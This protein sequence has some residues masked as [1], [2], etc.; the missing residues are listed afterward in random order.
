MRPRSRRQSREGALGT[1]ERVLAA[2]KFAEPADLATGGAAAGLLWN[3]GGQK[4][5][6][7]LLPKLRAA[8]SSE[9]WLL[10][11]MAV[12]AS[13]LERKSQVEVVR[14]IAELQ[15]WWVLARRLAAAGIRPTRVF[16]DELN[17][18][19][20]LAGTLPLDEKA[21]ARLVEIRESTGFSGVDV[22][23]VFGKPVTPSGLEFL[24]AS[25]P[26]PPAV[27]PLRRTTAPLRLVADTG[28]EGV[29]RKLELW[30][31]RIDDL[32]VSRDL[33]PGKVLRV[34]IKPHRLVA[35]VSFARLPMKVKVP[36]LW[37]LKLDDEL[38]ASVR[39]TRKPVTVALKDGREIRF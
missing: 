16:T 26:A 37:C 3:Q 25:R 19:A 20:A 15:G 28:L 35:S 14:A 18:L 34:E 30:Q 8:A 4:R 39:R 7:S 24:I 6:E 17:G 13:R 23:P 10:A 29:R 9:L 2:K 22:L 11:G 1:F 36:G 33:T 21:V 5:I 32:S 27:A 38:I 31:A 12:T